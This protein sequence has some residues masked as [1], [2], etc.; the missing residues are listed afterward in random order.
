MSGFFTPISDLPPTTKTD[1]RFD[2]HEAREIGAKNLIDTILSDIKHNI[3]YNNT[4]RLEFA[5]NNI[6][7]DVLAYVKVKLA[8]LKY[9]VTI[10]QETKWFGLFTTGKRYI[11][12][13]W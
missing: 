10:K 8:E 9:S 3:R 5:L 4:F 2:A 7:D 11:V 12:V 1:E 13:E 6:P